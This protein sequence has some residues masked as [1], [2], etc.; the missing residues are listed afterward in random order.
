MRGLFHYTVSFLAFSHA[1]LTIYYAMPKN[2]W[3][4]SPSV[5]LTNLWQM[6][7]NCTGHRRYKS[8][9]MTW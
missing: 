1:R 4:V 8:I 7:V 3:V 9:K 5:A 6:W 2:I